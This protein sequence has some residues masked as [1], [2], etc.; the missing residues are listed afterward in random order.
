MTICTECEKR[1]TCTEPC[2][3]VREI[4]YG[5]GKKRKRRTYPV[6]FQAFEA[7][8]T[9]QLN[10][11]QIESLHAISYRPIE[12]IELR[13]LLEQILALLSVGQRFVFTK[14]MEGYTNREIADLTGLSEKAIE[15]RHTRARK[16]LKRVLSR[17]NG[18]LR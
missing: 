2:D 6:D 10:R 12:K 17:M 1:E 14:K 13:I 11:F 4:T 15:Q 5:G 7:K 16:R 18:D 9:A 8:S 3:R